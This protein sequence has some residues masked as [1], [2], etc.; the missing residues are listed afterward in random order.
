MSE[1]A[2]RVAGR[3]RK[4]IR[5][6]AESWW[7]AFKLP[8]EQFPIVQVVDVGLSKHFGD[9][10]TF[11][12]LE[13]EQMT[14]S[15]GLTDPDQ[16]IMLIRRDVYDGACRGQGRDRFTLA[17]ELGHLILHGGGRYLERADPRAPPPTHK[18]WEDSEWQADTFAS[19]L[20]MPITVVKKCKTPGELAVRAG[21]SVSAAEVRFK[22]LN[23]EGVL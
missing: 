8:I 5:K 19:E 23:G 10:Y 9:R 2:Y 7:G 12:V 22:V 21:V 16:L 3:T 4:Q 6:V 11:A 13:R 14:N 20:L 15:H 18:K 17:H 1:L